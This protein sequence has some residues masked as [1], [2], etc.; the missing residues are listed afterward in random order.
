MSVLIQDPVHADTGPRRWRRI[1]AE[2][3]QD[4]E[5]TVYILGRGRTLF[6]AQSTLHSVFATFRYKFPCGTVC[7][8]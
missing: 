6:L 3:P 4:D 2:C 1:D 8:T 5:L 7:V